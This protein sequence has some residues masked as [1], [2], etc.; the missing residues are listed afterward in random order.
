MAKRILVV[1]DEKDLNEAYSLILS[2]EGY[3]VFSAFDGA[4]ALDIAKAENPDL[5]LLDLKMPNMDGLEFLRN[6]KDIKPKK[7]M[8]VVVFSNIDLEKDIEKAYSHGAVRYIL[9]AWASPK[10]L[11]KIVKDTLKESAKKKT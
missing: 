6:F 8:P 5:I 1:E 11:T 9:K 7:T 4:E 2:Q 3:K 10:E